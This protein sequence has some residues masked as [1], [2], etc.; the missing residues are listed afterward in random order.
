MTFTMTVHM[1]DDAFVTE[2]G[3]H[4][5]NELIRLLKNTADQVER[6]ETETTPFSAIVQ[7]V[8]GNTVGSWDIESD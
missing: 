7:D 8:N 1:D 4:Y 5:C 6:I 3:A 2:D